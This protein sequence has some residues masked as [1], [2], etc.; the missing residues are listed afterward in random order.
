MAKVS[1]L[2]VLLSVFILS[3]QRLCKT[4]P[5][6]NRWYS[7]PD[8]CYIYFGCSWGGLEQAHHCVFEN[9]EHEYCCDTTEH[10]ACAKVNENGF[11]LCLGADK[12]NLCKKKTIS[13]L[14]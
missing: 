2:L 11:P 12:D 3:F 7:K 8:I 9:R 10:P 4:S 5:D 6:C 14:E 13:Y 1:K